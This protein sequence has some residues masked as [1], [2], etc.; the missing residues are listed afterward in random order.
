MPQKMG[1]AGR[2]IIPLRLHSQLAGFPLYNNF[3]VARAI[4][5]PTLLYISHKI[6]CCIQRSF[7]S[8]ATPP[9]PSNRIHVLGVGNLGRLFAHALAKA[10]SPPPI[11]LLLHRASLI[12]EWEQAGRRIQVT[13]NDSPDQTG[14]FDIELATPEGPQDVIDNLIVTTKATKT[15]QA[16]STIKHRL[17]SNSTIL[18]A[19]NGMG[20]AEELSE[21]VFRDSSKR[22]SYLACVTSHGVYSEGPFRS[23]HA[24]QASVAIG[25]IAQSTAPQ[26]LIDRIVQAPVLSAREVSPPELLLLQLE[27]LVVNAMINPLTVIFNCRNGELFNRGAI[28]RI[29]RLLLQE[30][31][32]VLRSLPE[33]QD[34][35]TTMSRFSEGALERIILDVA[36]KTAKNTSSMLQDVRA[37][38]ETEIEYINGYLVERGKLAG[39]D[40]KVNEKL[41][42]MVKEGTVIT[43]DE[44]SE[45]FP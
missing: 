31:S 13:T 33:L 17:T 2:R 21:A 10:E 40:C 32:K 7:M 35:S 4:G 22:P 12:K 5:G 29:M 8:T 20:T 18:L 41:V 14:A 39:V 25:R 45:Y 27:K 36:D 38:R 1:A 34:E 3:G 15:V 23:V 30:A 19:Q 37:G 43:V 24:G 42:M 9:S 16:L 11:T 26:Y 44:A 6:E 28:V